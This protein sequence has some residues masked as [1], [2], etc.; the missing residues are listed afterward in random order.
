LV[1]FGKGRPTMNSGI[2]PV[3]LSTRPHCF[4]STSYLPALA[5]VASQ[6]FFE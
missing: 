6:N 1:T 2:L 4:D 5:A 3:A